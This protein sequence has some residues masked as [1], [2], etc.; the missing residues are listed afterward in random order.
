MVFYSND[1]IIT[2]TN[3]NEHVEQWS[4]FLNFVNQILNKFLEGLWI[5]SFELS[6]ILGIHMDFI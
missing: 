2:E 6:F 3:C 1:F 4:G 5:V